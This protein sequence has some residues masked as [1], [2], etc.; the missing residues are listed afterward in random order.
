MT[1]EK[2]FYF[3][4]S[5][6]A[7]RESK[8]LMRRHVMKGKNAGKTFHRPSRLA[9]AEARRAGAVDGFYPQHARYCNQE[10]RYAYWMNLS[11]R[12]VMGSIG[13][14]PLPFSLPV[15]VMPKSLMVINRCKRG[16][17]RLLK[18]LAN[19]TDIP[20]GRLWPRC[21]TAISRPSATFAERYHAHVGTRL[22]LG[23]RR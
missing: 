14:V 22:V 5:I 18:L 2:T 3:F 1:T 8:K 15:E 16:L 12:T 21:G 7:D 10:G 9:L 17:I 6:K 4:D 20:F 19:C 11:A 23:R 13:N